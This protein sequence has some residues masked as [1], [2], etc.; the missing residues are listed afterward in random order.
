[1]TPTH[2]TKAGIRYRYYV[3]LP[4]LHGEAR[5]AKVG[6]ITR[7]PAPDIEEIVVKSLNEHLRSQGGMPASTITSH[8][9]IAP[10]R[11]Y[12]YP[13]ARRLGHHVSAVRDREAG[14]LQVAIV[15]LTGSDL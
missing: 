6:S 13:A 10:K 8:S 11:S 7:V 3:S 1:M 12:R 5:T 14:W 15:S 4:C 2:A 9:A